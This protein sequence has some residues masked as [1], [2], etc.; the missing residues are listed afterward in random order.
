MAAFNF[1]NSPSVNDTYTANGVSFKWNGEI[2]QRISASTGAQGAT[3]PTGAQGATGATG[4]QGATGNNGSTGPT[5]PTGPTGAQGAQGATGATGA[6]GAQGNTGSGGAQGATGSG[7]STG[8]QGAAG[9][10]GSTGATGAQGATGSTGPTGAQGAT[11]S[12]GAQ[13]ALA[14]INSNTNNYVLTATGTANTIQGE[15]ALTFN[16]GSLVVNSDNTISGNSI[17]TYSPD[18][19]VRWQMGMSNTDGVSLLSKNTS[20]SYNTY[21]IDAGIFRVRTTGTNSPTEALRIDG[22]GRLLL[23]HTSSQD[24]YATSKLQIQ[25]TTAATSSL[26][27]LRHGNSPYLTLGSSGG[28]SLGAVD[29]LSSGDRIGQIT[30]AGADGTDTV[31]YTHLTLPTTLVV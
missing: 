18:G 30:F 29:A 31:S 9:A 28:S 3:G 17:I 16:A 26:S 10:Q 19:S 6:Q 8:A 22:N 5:G 13:G 21:M 24:V 2:W 7:G 4:A 15:S 11:G 12:T 1:P 23:G 14:T 25:G 27:L 20:G